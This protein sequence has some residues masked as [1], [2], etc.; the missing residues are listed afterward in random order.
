MPVCEMLL[1]RGAPT[2]NSEDRRAAVK[3]EVAFNFKRT[4]GKAPIDIEFL[5]I[6][7]GEEQGD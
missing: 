3:F 1:I 6:R 5:A 7:S 4:R 2:P